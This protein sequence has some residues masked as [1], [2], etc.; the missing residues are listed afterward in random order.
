MNC[1]VYSIRVLSALSPYQKCFMTDS[2]I[3]L[4]WIGLINHQL[5][6]NTNNKVS[7]CVCV[8]VCALVLDNPDNFGNSR[9]KGKGSTR[10]PLFFQVR[11]IRPPNP[12]GPVYVSVCVCVCWQVII[13]HNK[14]GPDLCFMSNKP[15]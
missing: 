8:C 10:K 6:R 1:K 4:C 13:R 5:S 11:E 9:L 12:P 7:L 15:T 14:H 2:L 3:N